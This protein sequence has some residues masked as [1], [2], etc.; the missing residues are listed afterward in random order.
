M[1][2][3]GVA[4]TTFRRIWKKRFSHVRLPK[5]IPL[6]KCTFCITTKEMLERAKR[7]QDRIKITESR[8]GH[9]KMVR[10]ER[11]CYASK[12]VSARENPDKCF[13]IIEDAMA[14]DKTNVP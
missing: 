5:Y 7:T 1:F 13:S 6:S 12:K 8:Q 10:L 3:Q 14:Q 2:P 9:I 4:F 11:E